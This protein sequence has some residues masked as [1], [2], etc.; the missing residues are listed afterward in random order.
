[1]VTTVAHIAAG[2]ERLT[3][4]QAA[5]LLG[6]SRQHV[7]DLCRRGVLPFETVGTHRRVRRE[8]VEALARGTLTRAA[9]RTL[10]LHR[11]VAGRLALDPEGTMRKARSNLERLHRV[12]PSG[13]AALWLEQWETVLDDGPETVF[14]VLTSRSPRAVELRQNSPFAGVL[15]PKDRQAVLTAFRS[16]WR[17]ENAA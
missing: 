4:G 7:V 11:A 13:M 16:C 9:T 15:S 6:T 14:E 12:H 1:M 3:T 2:H 17:R 8:D 10:W 5:A